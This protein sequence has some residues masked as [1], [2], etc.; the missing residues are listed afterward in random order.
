M[1]DSQ[2]LNTQA[3]IFPEVFGKRESEYVTKLNGLQH[4][5]QL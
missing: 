5:E 2:A 1:L 3:Q 4:D